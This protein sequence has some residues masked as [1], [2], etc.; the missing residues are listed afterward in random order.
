MNTCTN[1]SCWVTH[2]IA[3]LVALALLGSCG[4]STPEVTHRTWDTLE[5]DEIQRRLNEPTGSVL[6]D[7][8]TELIRAVEQRLPFLLDIVRFST[9]MVTVVNEVSRPPNAVDAGPEPM[10]PGPNGDWN[11]SFYLG[12]ACPG[13]SPL[14]TLPPRP[15]SFENGEARVDSPALNGLDLGDLL[16]GE[17][18]LLSFRQCQLGPILLDG[19]V[20]GHFVIDLAQ[21]GLT[22]GEPDPDVPRFGLALDLLELEFGETQLPFGVVGIACDGA[23]TCLDDV[24]VG[25]EL[26]AKDAGTYVFKFRVTRDYWQGSQSITIGAFASDGEA[27]CTFTNSAMGPSLSCDTM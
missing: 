18:F 16:S 23:T 7:E 1:P 21:L 24:S 14:G 17:N 13:D 2:R 6:G 11:T 12:L 9:H 20:P 15:Y 3:G 22:R 10:G 4:C 27:T 8:D 19:E 26:D 5:V 25:V